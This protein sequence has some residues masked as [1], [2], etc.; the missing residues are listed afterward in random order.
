MMEK[1]PDSQHFEEYA[2]QPFRTKASNN[3]NCLFGCLNY[4]SLNRLKLNIHGHL[5]APPC[6]GK[7]T[8]NAVL[9][10]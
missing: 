5:S 6:W 2:T 8:L 4:G 7:E 10:V 9:D 1:S 3:K